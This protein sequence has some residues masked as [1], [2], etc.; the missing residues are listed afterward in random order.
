MKK[1]F[2]TL[3]AVASLFLM[4]APSTSA[5]TFE[6]HVSLN[7]V[8]YV[9]GEQ[10]T[11]SILIRNTGDEPMEVKNVSIYFENWMMYTL[12]GWDEAGN[13]T[14]D[15]TDL[16]PIGS[17]KSVALDDVSFTVP[18]DGRAMSTN[19]DLWIYTSA[20]SPRHEEVY[21]DVVEPEVLAVQRAME[22]IVTLLTLVA[23]LG[24]VGAIII[25]AAVFLSARKPGVA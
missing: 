19:V 15:Y 5:A 24:F 7:K 16:D 3:T 25:A 23:I 17:N 6:V 10:G 11:L 13:M 21:V 9:P 20:P 14:I 1:L 8:Q 18:T 2:V 12:D 22:N 4:F